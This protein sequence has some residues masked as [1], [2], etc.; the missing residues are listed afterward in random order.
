[1]EEEEEE[2][3]IFK[4]RKIFEDLCRYGEMMGKLLREELSSEALLSNKFSANRLS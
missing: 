1:L 3:F 4:E 2:W